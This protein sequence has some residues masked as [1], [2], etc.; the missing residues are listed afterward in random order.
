VPSTIVAPPP[1]PD[2]TREPVEIDTSVAHASRIYDYLLGGTTNFA[3]DR[4]RAEHM[5]EAFYGGIEHPRADVRANRAFLGRAVRHLV[6]DVGIRQFLD[7]GTGIPNSDNVHA[8]AQAL[9]PESRIVYVDYDRIVQAH[10]RTLLRSTPEGATAFVAADV[11]DPD[12]IL[13]EA[14]ATLDFDRPI[15]LMLV[16][17]LHAVPDGAPEIVGRLVDALVPGSYLVLSHLARDINPEEMSEVERRLNSTGTHETFVLRDRAA[18]TG[19]FDGLE[20]LEP[21]VV[22]VDEWRPDADPTARSGRPGRSGCA[23][24]RVTPIYGAVA[25]KP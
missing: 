1:P 10:A 3:V 25:R 18:V 17:L 4:E 16:G 2:R 7:I 9:A 14:R 8:V 11:R 21:G 15:A 19:F 20:L 24:T 6:S 13:Q 12:H 23:G 5:A 22:P